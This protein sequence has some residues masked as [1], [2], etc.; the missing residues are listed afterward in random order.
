[1]RGVNQL[2]LGIA[3]GIATG[4]LWGIVF[5]VPQAL[6]DY[7]SLELSFGRYVFF[8]LASCLGLKRTWRD[9]SSFSW[10]DRGRVFLL[11]TSGFWLYT[12][13]LFQAVTQAGGV[14]TT[15]VIGMLPVTIPLVAKGPRRIGG[16]FAFGLALLFAGLLVLNAGAFAGTTTLK[17]AGLAPLLS[18]L[19]MWTWF[20]IANTEFVQR[21]PQAKVSLTN[22]MGLSSF[23]ILALIAP[24]CIDLAALVRHPDFGAFL[25]WSALIGCGSSWAANIL[26]NICSAR[27]P[28]TI[29]GPLVVA[30]T[31]FG[32]L[33]N[34]MFQHRM[35]TAA[36]AAAILL[37][38]LGVFLAIRA[39]ID[40]TRSGQ[41][42]PT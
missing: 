3:A 41:E 4:M 32:L 39:E 40:E 18:C 20:G 31:S 15:L 9:F 24:F 13:F 27:C 33:Y 23:A 1:M 2:T 21:N 5:V 12:L 25:A 42:S 6:P 29:S 28:A 10:R 37:F 38:G 30:E 17:L 22:L 35:P 7:S 14:L 19:A 34:F 11:S 26:W 36:E 8:G 16:R